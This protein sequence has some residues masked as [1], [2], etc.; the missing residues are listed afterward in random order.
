MVPVA[1][2]GFGG[3]K[4]GYK[5]ACEAI[6]R[7]VGQ[8]STGHFKAAINI[9]GDFNLAGETWDLRRM[10][11]A[12]GIEVVATITGDGRIGDIQRRTAPP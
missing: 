10:Y 7:L 3:T 4:T 12:M 9:L 1:A 6:G 11:E 8:G 5:V 2:P